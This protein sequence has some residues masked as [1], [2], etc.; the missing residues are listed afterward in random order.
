M[1]PCQ[2]LHTPR[3]LDSR[4]SHGVHVRLLWCATDDEVSVQVEDRRTGT[5]FVVPVTA[6]RRPLDVFHH[7]YA[8]AA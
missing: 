4:V 3:E 8:Y 1:T 6:G 7:P 5:A 2:I